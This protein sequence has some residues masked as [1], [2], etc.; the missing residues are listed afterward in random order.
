MKN[1][2]KVIYEEKPCSWC[3]AE[4]VNEVYVLAINKTYCR[5]KCM[6]SDMEW[7]RSFVKEEEDEVALHNDL[8]LINNNQMCI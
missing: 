6:V 7:A 5:P 2:R 3:F 4:I 8:A 1:L